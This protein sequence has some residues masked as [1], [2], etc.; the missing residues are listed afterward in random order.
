[1]K[2]NDRFDEDCLVVW[3][4]EVY[5]GEAGVALPVAATVVRVRHVA[6]QPRAINLLLGWGAVRLGR[7]GGR[8]GGAMGNIVTGS[9]AAVHV[10]S[11]V[12]P[13]VPVVEP[14]SILH[15]PLYWAGLG[16]LACLAGLVR[17]AAVRALVIHEA[18]LRVRGLVAVVPSAAVRH[19]VVREAL[20][21]QAGQPGQPRHK[22]CTHPHS[23]ETLSDSDMR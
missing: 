14:L 5:L 10:I 7:G 17:D 8:P 20:G 18:G 11:V 1:M 22:Y 3:A 23:R 13:V 15:N 21:Q 4:E 9:R 19:E 12:A 16:R 6:L 2:V